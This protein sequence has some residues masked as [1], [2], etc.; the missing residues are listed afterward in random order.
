MAGPEGASTLNMEPPAR[1]SWGI[2]I[3]AQ[4]HNRTVQGFPAPLHLPFIPRAWSLTGA[5][6]ASNLLHPGL[7]GGDWHCEWTVLD[8]GRP[9]SVPSTFL[10]ANLWLLAPGEQLGRLFLLG[11][12][13]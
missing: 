5:T 13:N 2:E 8:A 6:A 11:D 1:G 12:R 9:R 7:R 3:K 4:S 10:A